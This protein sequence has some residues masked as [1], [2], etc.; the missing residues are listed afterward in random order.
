MVASRFSG[1]AA[2]DWHSPWS[3]RQQ[4]G[5]WSPRHKPPE[6]PFSP[7][8]HVPNRPMSPRWGERGPPSVGK[9]FNSAPEASDM[10][11]RERARRAAQ[12][13]AANVPVILERA[14][15]AKA[16]KQAYFQHQMCPQFYKAELRARSAKGG[17]PIHSGDFLDMVQHIRSP[18]GSP[19][20]SAAAS[21]AASP[22]REPPSSPR[23][24]THRALAARAE[25]IRQAEETTT[26]HH[27]PSTRPFGS[28][29]YRQAPMMQLTTPTAAAWP[30]ASPHTLAP[31]HASLRTSTMLASPDEERRYM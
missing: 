11:H 24:P 4:V 26:P 17:I 10:L 13:T 12:R 19:S 1:A 5:P 9:R 27:T 18:H 30:T 29:R 31:Q 7:R 25:A 20:G 22:R 8:S 21:S 3:P 28:P 2:G 15:E 23:P 14:A 6:L 16:F